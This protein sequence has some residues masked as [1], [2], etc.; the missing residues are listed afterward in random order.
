MGRSIFRFQGQHFVNAR[1]PAWFMQGELE[2]INNTS[3]HTKLRYAVKKKRSGRLSADLQGGS[4][5][6]ATLKPPELGFRG[7]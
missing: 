3:R 1:S 6:I 7:S 2:Q 4:A 5:R